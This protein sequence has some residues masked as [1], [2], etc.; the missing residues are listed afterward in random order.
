MLVHLGGAHGRRCHPQAALQRV[1][2]CVQQ[3]ILQLSPLIDEVRGCSFGV[4]WH[5]SCLR[6]STAE[7]VDRKVP[8][9]LNGICKSQANAIAEELHCSERFSI[10]PWVHGGARLVVDRCA[11]RADHVMLVV[12]DLS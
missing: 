11:V 10:E 5:A 3:E 4:R 1:M 8:P 12:T 2:A 6:R 9:Y 7:P